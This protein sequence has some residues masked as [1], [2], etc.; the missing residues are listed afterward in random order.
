MSE[1]IIAIDTYGS[2]RVKNP[3]T[4]QLDDFSL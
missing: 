1:H 3:Q 2:Q 4:G